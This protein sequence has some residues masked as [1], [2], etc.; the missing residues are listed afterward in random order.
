MNT[1]T[2]D[3][4]PDTKP[5]THPYVDERITL[6]R[7]TNDYVTFHLRDGR[8]ISVPISW[9]WRLE[10]ATEEERQNYEVVGGGYGVHW[11]GIDEDLSAGGMLRGTPAPRPGLD[12]WARAETIRALRTHSGHSQ[13]EFARLL[14]VRQATVSDWEGG[15]V[16]QLRHRQRLEALAI[17]VGCI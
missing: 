12:K 3:A 15:S 16:P 8:V 9:S 6:V 2:P 11:P 13:A 17:E 14:D 10:E 4:R 7:V 1:A 5:Q